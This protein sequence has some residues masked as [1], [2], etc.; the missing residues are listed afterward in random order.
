MLVQWRR[1]RSVGAMFTVLALACGTVGC[2][3]KNSDV[4]VAAGDDEPSD[5]APKS[6]VSTV[7]SKKP[8]SGGK[9]T[10]KGK[11]AP[12]GPTVD[13]IPLD[14]FFDRP[15]AVAADQTKVAAPSNNVASNDAKPTPKDDA[16]TKPM[17]DAPKP[18]AGGG[19]AQSWDKVVST[20]VLLDSIKAC[21]NQWE[22]R[23]GSV[24][25]YN[26]AQLE[27]PVF[28]TE[29]VLLAEIARMHPGEIRWKDKAK[30]IRSL[31]MDVVKIASGADGKGKKAFDSINGNFLKI[32]DI[33]DGNAADA[34]EAPD[35]VTLEESA[36]IKYLMKR[37]ERAESNLKNNAGSEENLKK[38]SG[39][40][41]K[42]AIVYALISYA[43]KDK[44]Y[45]YDAEADYLK[46]ADAM[47][48]ASKGMEKAA[49]D[50]NFAE[51]DALRNSV[52]QKCSDCHMT[53]R[54]GQ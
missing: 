4:A 37:L 9:S 22:Q 33:L 30:F 46:Q 48:T 1:W 44:S 51:F 8:G 18:A 41:G 25:T 2:G 21:R 32:K 35:T 40:A 28:A 50:S 49:S 43:I 34:G 10:G 39:M 31:S 13:G 36:N 20:E 26:S 5:P 52:T 19:G 45:G 16:G 29:M 14:V 15:L 38:N 24:Q 53:Y 27:M 7:A 42:D 17:P 12:K 54:T 47:F 23:L 11:E 3:N 6:K